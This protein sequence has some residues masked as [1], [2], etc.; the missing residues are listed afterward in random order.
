M[1]CEND[2]CAYWEDGECILKEIHINVRV[3]ADIRT[4]P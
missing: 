4:T 1:H 2:Y 3:T